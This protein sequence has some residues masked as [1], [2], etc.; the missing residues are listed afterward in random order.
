MPGKVV[1]STNRTKLAYTL[2]ATAGV[3]PNNPPWQEVLTGSNGFKLSPKRGRSKDIRADGQAPGT[4]L[5]DIESSGSVAFE[6]KFAAWD[7]WFR[8]A[9][10][11]DWARKAYRDNAGVADSV[12]TAATASTDAYTVTNPGGVAAFVPGHLVLATGFG[13]AANNS[14][15]KA[16]AGTTSTNVNAPAAPGLTDETVPPG[17]AKLQAVGFE[18]A[19]ADITATASGLGSTALNFTTLGLQAGEWVYVGGTAAGNQFATAAN[20][21]WARVSAIAA[22]ALTFDVLP[23]GWTTD[24]GTGKAIQVFFGDFLKNGTTIYSASFERQQLGIAVPTYEYFNG[25]FLNNLQMQIAGA[26]EIDLSAE[27]L[28]LGGDPIA[29]S[30]KAGSTDIAAS[31]VYGTMTATANI[32]D[33]VEGGVSV[34]GGTNCMIG[35]TLRVQNNI[36]RDALPGPLGT[37]AITV[38]AFMVSGNIDTYLGDQTILA[39]GINDTPSSFSFPVGYAS[40]NREGY[41]VDL[42]YIKLAP[43]SDIPGANQGRKVSGP[44]EA[45][46]HPTLGYT[47]SIGRFY[48]LPG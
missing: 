39:K 3:T 14:L 42:P 38:G 11:N 13:Q 46:P 9:L 18:G 47:M 29:T 37:A 17:T 33:L 40:G 20:R 19:T 36:S 12:I 45:E 28:G 31:S 35:A 1:A 48:Y 21:G 27:F 16:L 15:F 7:D 34:M 23:T 8:M 10:K 41:R 43:D 22:T 6:M 25:Q 5:T 44:F 4:F 24:S 2:E 26:K 30:R 32:G